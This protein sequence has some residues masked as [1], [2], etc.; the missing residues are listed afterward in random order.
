MSLGFLVVKVT[1]SD[2][3]V[4][5]DGEHKSLPRESADSKQVLDLV[6]VYNN[7]R[8]PEVRQ[9]TKDKLIELLSPV[10]RIVFAS[11]NRF[12]FDNGRQLFLKGTDVPIPEVLAEKILDFIDKNLPVEALINFWKHLLLNP[13][14]R[15]REQLYGFIEHR[16]IAITK[17]GYLVCVKAVAVKRKYNKE[18]G[19]KIVV[20][21]YDENT[22]ELIKEEFV[23]DM[24][25]EPYHNG[26]YGMVVQMGKA[27]T[28][29]REECDSNPNQTCSSGLH[30]GSI[31]YVKDFG[32]GDGV[33]LEVLV[34]PR[35]VVAVP[36]DYNNT[37][38]R[39]CEYYPI[40]ITNGKNTQLYLED[41]YQEITAAQL[42]VELKEHSKA[43]AEIIEK[44][45]KNYSV[46]E[47][48]TTDLQNL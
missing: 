33:I 40:A 48:I 8:Q 46:I 29:P 47:Q 16:D 19:E 20:R 25:F 4:V 17:R 37:K 24:L 42:E 5:I 43:R 13:D 23:T 30:V 2:I 34:S 28:M 10:K 22:G 41:D 18:T 15:V 31:E 39:C 1:P 11:D 45:E 3:I 32:R 7:A 35:H 12:E 44:I 6:E 27:V 9:E 14:V 26:K 38:M 21:E 36:T